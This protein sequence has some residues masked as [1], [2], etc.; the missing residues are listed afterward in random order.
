MKSPKG[1][2][3]ENDLYKMAFD[4]LKTTSSQKFTQH[5]KEPI[6]H[7]ILKR[8]VKQKGTMIKTTLSKNEIDFILKRFNYDEMDEDE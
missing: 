7:M 3:A 2:I 1:F 6:D 5:L 8:E 4:E